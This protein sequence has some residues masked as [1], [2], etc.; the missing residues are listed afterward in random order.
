MPVKD[1][2]FEEI[3]GVEPVRPPAAAGNR[4][5]FRLPAQDSHE[6]HLA[7]G[8]GQRDGVART[9]RVEVIVSSDPMYG[10]YVDACTSMNASIAAQF[11]LAGPKKPGVHAPESR[12]DVVIYFLKLEKRK[13][14]IA[15]SVT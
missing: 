8:H 3:A 9:V 1:R 13:F 5:T 6:I 2:R 11:I 4:G 7:I 12:F 15:K 10:P 14:R